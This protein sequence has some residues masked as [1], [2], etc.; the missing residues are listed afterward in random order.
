MLPDLSSI[1][2]G[3]FHV[4]E[5]DLGHYG[6]ERPAWF[7]G[8]S[9]DLTATDQAHLLNASISEYDEPYDTKEEPVKT[10]GHTF[11]LETQQ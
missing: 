6:L 7:E 10:Y 9:A 2:E 4:L 11:R 5:V 1:G 3:L 8:V